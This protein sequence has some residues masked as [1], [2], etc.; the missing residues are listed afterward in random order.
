MKKGEKSMRRVLVSGYYGFGNTGDEAILMAIVESL[1]KF[2]SDI[3][4]T[5]LS[6]KPLST[7]KQYDI[8]AVQRTSPIAIIREI[9]RTDLVI[10]GGGGLLQDI[11]SNRSIPYYLFILYVAKKLNK[12]VMFYANGVGPVLRDI[13]KRMIKIVGNMVDL[14][15]V[16][17]EQSK[18]EFE[19]LGISNPPIIV[20]ADPAFALNSID[21]EAGYKMLEKLD[22]K[23]TDKRPRIGVSVRQW[24]LNKSR[25]IIASACDYLIQSHKA[26]IIFLP[27]QFPND[28]QESLEVMKL[29]KEKAS[30]IPR[31]MDPR[32]VLWLSGKMDLIFGMRLH[33]LIFG[34]MNEV[35]LVGLVYDPKVENFLQRVEQPSAGKPGDFDLVALCKLLEQA[36]NNSSKSQEILHEKK[37]QLAVLAWEN[38]R[39]AID[40]LEGANESR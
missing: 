20:T 1:K 6:A 24:N 3:E 40:L 2:K 4:I 29:M 39:L 32:G 8:K 18:R 31:F 26:N 37:Q 9:A 14:I 35:P 5:A 28:Y 38:A 21:D 23:I 16:R 11:T 27:M 33:A 36:L 34:A 12:K 19:N 10:S 17:D 22:I 13:N 7:Q 30:I 15:T 25:K